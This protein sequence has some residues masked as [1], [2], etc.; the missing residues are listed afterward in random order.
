MKT[1]AACIALLVAA[2]LLV[3]AFIDFQSDVETAPERIRAGFA[4]IGD[5]AAFQRDIAE[6]D[7]RKNSEASRA[8]V[9]AA[10]LVAGLFMLA[11]SKEQH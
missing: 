5:A 4:D 2:V 8:V 1:V 3:G 11:R 7:A 9:G 6:N 10:F